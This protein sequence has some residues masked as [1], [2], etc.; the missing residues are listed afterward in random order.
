MVAADNCSRHWWMILVSERRNKFKIHFIFYFFS[1]F[2]CVFLDLVWDL[3]PK[4][5]KIVCVK[6]SQSKHTA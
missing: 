2:E 1:V 5:L 3:L 4:T 6:N